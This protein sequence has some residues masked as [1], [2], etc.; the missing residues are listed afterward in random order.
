MRNKTTSSKHLPPAPPFFLGLTLLL[1][2]L[3]SPHPQVAQGDR[4]WGLR[5]VCHTLS[6]LLL[7]PQGEDFSHSSS[8]PAWGA[9]NGRQSSIGTSSM[10]VLLTCFH[11]WSVPAWVPS[12]AYSPSGI[13][14]SN[15]HP[16]WGHKSCQKT[17]TSVGSSLHGSWQEPA[18]AWASHGQGNS[19][20]WAFMCG[21]LPGL[22]VDICS[23]M[24]LHG[25]QGT[26][27][28]TMVISTGWGE[29]LLWGLKHLHPLVLHSPCCL[30]SCFSHIVSLLYPAADFFS[31]S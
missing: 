18:P 5:S 31:P 21:V 2:A 11:A 4:E 16:P 1:N 13:E 14:C 25:Q 20:L 29:S 9:S 27:C 22:Q 7:P 8:A 19:L 3:P 24:D 10:W 26:A 23:A 30:Q 28:L 6:L 12:T 17:C 15:V